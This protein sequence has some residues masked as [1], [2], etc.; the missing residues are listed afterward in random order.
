MQLATNLVF[1]ATALIF[2]KSSFSKVSQEYKR[3]LPAALL[4][5]LLIQ[6]EKSIKTIKTLLLSHFTSRTITVLNLG[7]VQ[8]LDTNFNNIFIAERSL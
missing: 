8:F 1:F 6:E 4:L 3:S 7:I 5:S 2:S